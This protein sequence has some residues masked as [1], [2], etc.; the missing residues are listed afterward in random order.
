MMVVAVWLGGCS[1]GGDKTTDDAARVAQDSRKPVVYVVNYPL[2]YFASRIAGDLVDVQFPAPAEIDPA[3]WKP[4]AGSVNRYQNAD[5]I[6]LNGATYAKW[7]PQVSLPN[8]KV[9]DTSADFR[10]QYISLT[11]ALSHS[12]GPGGEHAHAGTAF[13]TWLDLA[14]AAE[15]ARAIKTAFVKKWPDH[16]AVFETN[17]NALEKD[18]LVL[19]QDL[20]TIAALD[21]GQPLVASHPVYQYLARRYDLNLD[22]VHWE[23]DEGPSDEQWSELE[24]MLE[25]HPAKWMIWEGGPSPD[26]VARLESIGV[27][28]IVFDPCGNTPEQGDFLS[29]MQTNVENLKSAFAKL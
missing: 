16:E 29:T 8:S 27:R 18:L 2:H 28:S 22:A 10:S 24:H 7:V 14:L 6:L 21:P 26:T 17:F 11:E 3:F 5:L 15:H 9:V 19:D 20:R 1:D 12:H 4:G 25:G 13:T 23:P